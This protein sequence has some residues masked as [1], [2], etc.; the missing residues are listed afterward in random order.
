MH[1][2]KNFYKV[3]H[4][5]INVREELSVTILHYHLMQTSES[6]DWAKTRHPDV[7][8]CEK[9][10]LN[11][12]GKAPKAGI[13]SKSYVHAVASKLAVEKES[14][15]WKYAG[16]ENVDTERHTKAWKKKFRDFGTI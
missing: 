12:D 16:I 3:R 10:S 13:D 14:R 7:S 5:S 2:L 11:T 15:S 6:A 9:K 1:L 8:T 4:N